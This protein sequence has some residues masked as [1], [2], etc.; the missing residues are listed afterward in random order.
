MVILCTTMPFG[1]VLIG[2]QRADGNDLKRPTRQL[3]APKMRSQSIFV[4]GKKN[5]IT[6]ICV[7]GTIRFF[8]SVPQSVEWLDDLKHQNSTKREYLH[9]CYRQHKLSDLAILYRST[10]ARTQTYI[11]R[12]LA[13]T[14]L[15]L[16]IIVSERGCYDGLFISIRVYFISC[17]NTGKYNFS[18]TG[19]FDQVVFIQVQLAFYQPLP[20]PLPQ[21]EYS[22]YI[23]MIIQLL[24]IVCAQRAQVLPFRVRSS[25]YPYE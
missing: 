22:I 4:H 16:K 1:K 7:I 13:Q 20:P 19:N 24:S 21:V 23:I 12:R 6:Y 17:S 3:C 25:G 2:T 5:S 9:V 15:P 11:I 8:T 14:Q 18:D 10:D